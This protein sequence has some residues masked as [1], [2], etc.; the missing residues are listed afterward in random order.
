MKISTRISSLIL[1]VVLAVSSL[2]ICAFASEDIKSGIGIVDVSTSLRLRSAPST[3]AKILDLAY[4]GEVVVVVGKSGSWYKVIFN[5]QEGYMH[6]DYLDVYTKKNVELG[7]GR[8]NA[9]RVNLRSG[10]STSS[11]IVGKATE[12]T[13]A[14]IIGF[15][16]GW[17]KVICKGQV[18]YVRSDLL[19]LTEI[20]YENLDSAKEPLFF[21]GGKSTG[22][23]P[24]ASALEAANASAPTTSAPATSESEKTTETEKTPEPETNEP[25]ETQPE[26][27]EPEVEEEPEVKEEP[28]VEQTSELGLKIVAEAKKYIGVPYVW[29]GSSPSGFDCSGFTQYVARACGISINRTAA[30]QWKNGTYVEKSDLQ[31]GDLVFFANTYK[32]GISHVGIYV[33]NGMFLHASDNGIAYGDLNTEYNLSHYYG[34][35]RLG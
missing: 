7:Y 24:S 18:C 10:P 29:C 20:P 11:S 14:Y 5:Q 33:G 19:D 21:V 1:A 12:G 8:I 32:K 25:E 22:V 3:S 30:N 13:S 9:Y 28:V 35:R 16:S 31:P 23:T 4:D 34:A 17:Y 27:T 26:A 6:S 2:A 15:N